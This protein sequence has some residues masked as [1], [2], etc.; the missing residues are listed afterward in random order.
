MSGGAHNVGSC[1]A[2][3]IRRLLLAHLADALG[4]DADYEAAGWE[5]AVLGDD[6]SGGYYGAG[7]DLHH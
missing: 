6:G 4:R 1:T 7:P 5:L 3:Y 2:C